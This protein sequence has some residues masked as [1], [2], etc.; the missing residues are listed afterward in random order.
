MDGACL[1]N[2]PPEAS[3]ARCKKKIALGT[4]QDSILEP[5]LC[6]TM[7]E[8]PEDVFFLGIAAT[9]V[10]RDTEDDAQ[11]RLNQV[12][13]RLFTWMEDH[14]FN[15]ADTVLLTKRRIPTNA[16]VQVGSETI[17]IKEALRSTCV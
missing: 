10:V 9:M 1:Q 8:M 3:K 4:A 5:D 2:G 14:G 7:V 6:E 12:M 11:R 16:E 17:R 13:T 15:L